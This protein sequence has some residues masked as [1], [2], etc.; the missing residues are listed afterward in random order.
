MTTV[1]ISPI[2]RPPFSLITGLGLHSHAKHRL[3]PAIVNALKN[4]SFKLAWSFDDRDG[5]LLV[6]GCRLRDP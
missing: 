3:K 6:H 4:N 5:S 2:A 1:I